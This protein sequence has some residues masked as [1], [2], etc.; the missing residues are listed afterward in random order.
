MSGGHNRKFM[1]D[2]AKYASDKI[3]LT[4]D[5]GMGFWCAEQPG[6]FDLTEVSDSGFP[7]TVLIL[8]HINGRAKPR[9]NTSQPIPGV[10]IPQ[11]P[12]KPVR[13][14]TATVTLPYFIFT[15]K[16]GGC[17]L[18]LRNATSATTDF[19]HDATA[20][21]AT[22]MAGWGV[23]LLASDYDPTGSGRNF[24]G[25]CWWKDGRWRIATSAVYDSSGS[26]QVFEKIRGDQYPTRTGA[27][28]R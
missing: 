23:T 17:G 4:P 21:Q 26:K 2:P 10:Y 19:S 27:A 12:Y 20:E 8:R 16:L 15:T 11:D 28:A 14:V 18:G 7:G 5:D 13:P 24:T 9:T 1:A 6:P 25:F 3:I 22:N